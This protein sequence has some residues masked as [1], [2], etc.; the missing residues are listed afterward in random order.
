GAVVDRLRVTPATWMSDSTIREYVVDSLIEE[1]ALPET[2]IRKRVRGGFETVQSSNVAQGEVTVSV[3]DGV[4]TLAGELPT[5]AHKRLAGVLA[6]WV[7]GTR[8]V[9]DAL[10]VSTGTPDN[11]DEITKAVHAALEK[12]PSLDAE[13]IRVVTEQDVVTLSGLV[14]SRYEREIAENDAWFVFGVADVVNALQVAELG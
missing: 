9:V 7:P 14:W 11:E 1:A 13:Q 8:E 2:V 10:G 4:V 6:W 5:R 3:E 12:D